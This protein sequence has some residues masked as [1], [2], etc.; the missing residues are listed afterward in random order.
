MSFPLGSTVYQ[1][2]ELPLTVAISGFKCDNTVIKCHKGSVSMVGDCKYIYRC[3]TVGIDTVEVFIRK[4]YKK[5]RIGQQVF[6]VKQ[7]PSPQ[8]NVGGLKGG[9][10]A[11]SALKAQ[12]GV[13]ASFYIAG[14]HWEN[15]TV[16][17]FSFII[18]RSGKLVSSTRNDGNLFNEE[19]RAAL[20]QVQSGDKVLVTDIKGCLQQGGGD[21]KTL[22]FTIE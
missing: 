14:N 12:Q 20:Q 13:G 16:E 18:L 5:H 7:R 21:L 11:K 1:E 6:E 10:V 15:C 17:S 4:G 3:K 2:S 8:A 9:T 19:T 22:E